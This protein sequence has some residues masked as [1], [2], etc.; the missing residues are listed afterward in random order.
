MTGVQT[1]ALPI[2]DDGARRRTARSVD[3]LVETL[4]LAREAAV[5]VLEGYHVVEYLADGRIP[6]GVLVAAT[7]LVVEILHES[8]HSLALTAYAEEVVGV[9]VVEV[10]AFHEVS[11]GSHAVLEC[12]SEDGQTFVG[13]LLVVAF[14]A[15]LECVESVE[16]VASDE[17][18]VELDRKSVV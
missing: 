10:A 18:D 7:A 16:E 8:E 12:R 14:V 13:K 3:H 1:C 17:S 4:E 11:F 15:V 5:G 9:S 6:F 2:W